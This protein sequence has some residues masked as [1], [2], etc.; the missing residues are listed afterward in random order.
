[1]TLDARV[2]VE[3]LWDREGKGPGKE[4]AFTLAFIGLWELIAAIA[5]L[6]HNA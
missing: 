2:G 5:Y 3:G 4:T 6:L 1:M